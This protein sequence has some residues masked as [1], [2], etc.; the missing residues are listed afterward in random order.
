MSMYN[1]RAINALRTLGIWIPGDPVTDKEKAF[2]FWAEVFGWETKAPTLKVKVQRFK[3]V[4]KLV[5]ELDWSSKPEFRV[6][7]KGEYYYSNL[8]LVKRFWVIVE[9]EI[10]A[11]GLSW[12][13]VRTERNHKGLCWGD[14]IPNEEWVVKSSKNKKTPQRGQRQKKKTSTPQAGGFN[15]IEDVL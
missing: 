14:T 1:N 15:S 3:N 7:T 12:Y 9:H 10:E 5:E 8:E 11:K 13:W 6:Y 2:S 4:Q